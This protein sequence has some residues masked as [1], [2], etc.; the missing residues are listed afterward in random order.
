M[1]DRGA[2]R[3]FR[4]PDHNPTDRTCRHCSMPLS[5]FIAGYRFA[6]ALI[7]APMAVVLP[8]RPRPVRFEV[9]AGAFI[10]TTDLGTVLITT[11]RLAP[12]PA[13]IVAVTINPSPIWPVGLRLGAA[14]SFAGR[15]RVRP[16][17]GCIGT[18]A[19]G[20]GRGG[21]LRAAFADL[22]VTLPLPAV[23]VRLAAGPTIRQY[24]Y[25]DLICACD[26]PGPGELFPEPFFS[27]HE[28]AAFHLAIAAIL[29]RAGQPAPLLQAELLA[30]RSQ[31]NV[32]QR[33]LLVSIGVRF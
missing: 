2:G 25:P 23:D 27:R 26:P 7:V 28:A 10:P 3:A 31:W 9:G 17:P 11:G 24:A 1:E 21:A 20:S 8:Q 16:S 13:G 15:T 12:G 29:R 22:T 4:D 14:A 30:S 19:P 6:T 32:K 33:D 18:C 5:R